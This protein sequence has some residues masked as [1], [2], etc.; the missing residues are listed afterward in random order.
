MKK[1]VYSTAGIIGL[2]PVAAFAQYQVQTGFV[3][4][5]INLISKLIS[6][7]FPALTAIA[8]IVF[9]VMLIRYIMATPDKK[10]EGRKGIIYSLVA[11]FIIVSLFGILK[12][13]QNITGTAGNNTIDASQVPRV[14]LG[15]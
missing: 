10:E 5:V 13:L 1:L 2:L 3:D 6:F 12:V 9:I 15:Y 14:D 11:L 8:V 4:S 7:A